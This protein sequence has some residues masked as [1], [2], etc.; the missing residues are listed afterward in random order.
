MSALNDYRLLW[1]AALLQRGARRL[2]IL[3]GILAACIAIAGVGAGFV[4]HS[5]PLGLRIG[6]GIP[7]VC[8]LVAWHLILVPGMVRMNTPD[9]ACLVPRMRRRM[10]ELAVAGWVVAGMAGLLMPSWHAAPL[11][12]L[13]VIAMS[14]GRTGNQA[15]TI[16]IVFAALGPTLLNRLPP[17]VVAIFLTLPGFLCA[18]VLAVL[19]GAWS[20][21]IVLP[22][23]GDL[24]FNQRKQMADITARTKSMEQ[25]VPHQRSQLNT[26]LYGMTLRQAIRSGQPRRLMLHALGP[27]AQWIIYL[28]GFGLAVMGGLGIYFAL[29]YFGGAAPR[30]PLAGWVLFVTVLL[31]FQL[32]GFQKWRTLI[33]T[34]RKEEALLRLAARSPAAD[35][36]NRHLAAGLVGQI[37]AG[38]CASMCTVVALGL[39]TGVERDQLV[40]LASLS[41]VLVMPGIASV[42]LDYSREH[43]Q[44]ALRHLVLCVLVAVPT[45]VSAVVLQERAGAWAWVLLSLCTNGIGALVAARRWIAMLAAPPAFPASRFA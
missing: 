4:Q 43:E 29:L 30:I 13:W 8:L 33:A 25:G 34:H 20:I 42:L 22:A 35:N 41:T 9:N 5:L 7:L 31:V 17:P 6:A 11:V 3:L 40:C 2:L 12:V 1:R 32:A 23:G 19:V 14:L 36:W 37:M 38:A 10:V 26:G 45:L 44:W 21:R 28:P 16:A 15:S 27:G 24:H 18:C 39:L